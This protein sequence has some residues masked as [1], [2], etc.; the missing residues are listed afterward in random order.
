[1]LCVLHTSRFVGFCALFALLCVLYTFCFVGFCALSVFC[2]FCTISVLWGF[3][4]FLFCCVFST[5]SLLLYVWTRSVL[6]YDLYHIF[7]STTNHIKISNTTT[8]KAPTHR[9][10]QFLL[11]CHLIRINI[12]T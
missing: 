12:L 7:I 3:V 11:N 2:V 4:H 6:M 10:S 8:N 5:F 9:A 1:L